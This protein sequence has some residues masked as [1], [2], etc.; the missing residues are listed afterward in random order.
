MK[1][2]DIQ[3]VVSQADTRLPD[4]L[5]EKLN[6]YGQLIFGSVLLSLSVDMGTYLVFLFR[7]KF[8]TSFYSFILLLRIL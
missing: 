1:V 6:L 3:C 8:S 7:E 2:W 5:K 4:E